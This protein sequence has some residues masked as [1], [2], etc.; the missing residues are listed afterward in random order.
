MNPFAEL[1]TVEVSADGATWSAYPRTVTQYP[2][3]SCAGWHPVYANPDNGIDPLGPVV[4]D[5]DAAGIVSA[6]C[7]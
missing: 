1:A 6:L 5:L 4:F 3:G 7:S 2:Y